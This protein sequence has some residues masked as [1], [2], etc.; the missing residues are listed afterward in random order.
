MQNYVN[1][2]ASTL[3]DSNA[4]V[5]LPYATCT[6]YEA[7]TLVKA[8]LYSDDG[9]T[10]L[11]NPF[12]ASSTAQVLFYAANGRYDLKVFKSGYVPVTIPNI[13]LDDLLAPSGS[14]SVGYLPAGTGAVA[15]TVQT[16]LRESV[17][18]KDF[19][20]VGN[21]VTDDTAAIQQAF[22][23]AAAFTPKKTV[24]FPAG[25][26][27]I[28]PSTTI[29]ATGCSIDGDGQN[30]SIIKPSALTTAVVAGWQHI[31]YNTD[32]NFTVSNIQI[33]L[34]NVTY[35]GVYPSLQRSYHLL[36]YN[37]TNWAIRN[38][39]F[40][41]ISN[42]HIGV[43]ANGGN[44][45][46]ITD[47]YFENLVPS[48]QYSQAINIQEYSGT[49]RVLNNVMNGTGLFSNSGDGLVS[50]N[51]AYNISFGAGLAFGPFIDCKNNVITNNHCTGGF[52]SPDVNATY[53][54]G[55]ENWGSDSIISGNYCSNNS[56]S[57]ISHGGYRGVV[58]GNICLNNGIG[59]TGLN[60]ITVFSILAPITTSGSN[61]VITG[62]LCSDT[63][64]VK[65]QA[66]GYR[67][68]GFG[69]I[70]NML[71]YGNY[72]YNNLTGNQLTVQT[73]PQV[74]RSNSPAWM[75]NMSVGAATPVTNVNLLS[76]S[77]LSLTGTDASA[78][79]MIDQFPSTATVGN[80]GL[81]IQL[82]TAAAV[83]SATSILINNFATIAAGAI[84]TQYGIFIQDLTTGTNIRGIQCN[85]LAGTNKYNIYASGTAPNYFAG[86][87]QIA[88]STTPMLRSI[89][90]MSNGAAAAVGTLTNA[91]V[92]GNPTKWIAFNDA[93]VTRYIPAW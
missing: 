24:Y 67:E 84:T 44:Y 27:V 86:E 80:R 2:I 38:C 21:G 26:Y 4:L 47:C 81:N 87:V 37:C 11:T 19:G 93:G 28:N 70:A 62:N 29:D 6:V 34:T 14:N 5:L 25:T 32:S 45:W 71:V 88:G 59:G 60:G 31:T 54:A 51:V 10:P 92:A 64:A 61:S 43:Y 52:G 75:P 79:Q 7:G 41:G 33:D 13:E 39:S 73:T 8:A 90:A 42:N 49:H 89:A 48:I 63:Q 85:V 58:S 72:F 46:E 18:V 82:Y 17:S 74:L 68:A 16:K 78:M 76:N 30:V 50:N 55:I 69:T 56:G 57:G 3:P 65:T 77:Y 22:T 91:P 35:T 15:T 12:T 83:T 53:T 36:V 9:I 66:Y 23:S 40:T 20:A 1:N